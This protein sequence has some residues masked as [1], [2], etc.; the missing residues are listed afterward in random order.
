[1]LYFLLVLALE[2]VPPGPP[3]QINA[4][5]PDNTGLYFGI[6]ALVTAVST[7][8]VTLMLKFRDV[9]SANRADAMNEMQKVIDLYA[10]DI[11]SLKIRE[12]DHT[13]EIIKLHEQQGGCKEENA[14]L[15]GEIRM[16]QASVQRLQADTG[17]SPPASLTGGIIVI[18]MSGKMVAVSPAVTPQLGWLS[19]N[20]SGLPFDKII[21]ERHRH[22]FAEM[23]H[24][25]TTS[26]T[27]PSPERPILLGG[28]RGV[29]TGGPGDHVHVRRADGGQG[30]AP[31]GRDPQAPEALATG[32]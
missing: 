13:D 9:K 8:L 18:D 17:T 27:A 10:K 5:S 6:T 23:I 21:P 28:Y 14:R 31:D 20:L 24:Q 1:M 12:R 11:E 22:L 19:K 26:G 30:V 2:V 32:S 3:V 7:A 4:P 25:L 16:L 15:K 29:G